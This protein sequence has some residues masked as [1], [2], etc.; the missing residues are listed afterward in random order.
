MFIIGQK[1]CVQTKA[2]PPPQPVGCGDPIQEHSTQ[3]SSFRWINSISHHLSGILKNRKKKKKKLH[4]SILN[5]SLIMCGPSLPQKV[6]KSV[7]GLVC[8]RIYQ[9]YCEQCLICQ[10]H[11]PGKIVKT[12][13]S[14]YPTPLE[15]FE[16]LQTDFILMPKLS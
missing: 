1:K 11:N 14:T 6:H 4:F 10:Q 15:P 3:P 12:T 16:A 7:L 8:F 13:I 9:K 5:K 2:R